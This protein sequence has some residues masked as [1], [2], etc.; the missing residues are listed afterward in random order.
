MIQEKY[1]DYLIDWLL[2]LGYTHCFFLAGGNIMHLLHSASRRMTCIPF[3]HEVTA[4]IAAEYF[5]ELNQGHE[6]KAF[7]LVTAGPGLTNLITAIA[8]AYLE[9]RELLVL[10]GQVKTEDLSTTDLR[11]RGIQE[12]KGSELVSSITKVSK[13]LKAP[14]SETEFKS[15]VQEGFLSRK[16]PVFLEIPL[17]VQGN[18]ANQLAQNSLNQVLSVPHEEKFNHNVF[19]DLVKSARPVLL[20][21][22]GLSRKFCSEN[23]SKLQ[24]LEIPIMTTWNGADRYGSAEKNYWGRPNTWGQR[25]SNVLIQQS[26]FILAIGT[27]L[28]LQQTGFNWQNFAPG[29]QIVQV[30]IDQAELQK[31]HPKVS[32]AICADAD[33]FLDSLLS[34]LDEHGDF[35]SE[36]TEWLAFGATVKEKLPL[37]EKANKALVGY[38]N[39]YDFI[40]ELSSHLDSND[41]VIPSSSGSSMTVTMQSL[42]QPR[43]CRIVTN[44]SLA[45]MGYG[46]GGAI[47]ASLSTKSRVIHIEGD[48]GFL[49]N[50]QDLG[51]MRRQCLPI[52]TFIFSNGGYAS[53]RMTQLSYFNGEYV[54]CD[55]ATGLGLPDWK[56]LAN[57]FGINFY[58]INPENPFDQEV[59]ARLCSP[60]PEFFLVPISQEQTYFPKITSRVTSSGSMESTPLHLMSPELDPRLYEECYKFNQIKE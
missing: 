38:L 46:L 58:E 29:A 51:T 21:G 35:N 53:I 1:S 4:G 59:L 28:G 7:V 42:L 26:D 55:E 48:G 8:G 60:R 19:L 18:K 13:T 12:L 20:L 30:D 39:P 37:S 43:G 52:K 33:R 27:R 25:Y 5:N 32:N 54:G 34:F 56:L 3:S 24:K 16:G 15:L 9:S 23:Y 41:V 2:E 50:I 57:S 11:Q 6:K 36:R 47:G 49:Q 17:D 10:G 22:G 44:K 31:G 45:S 14:V 40:T